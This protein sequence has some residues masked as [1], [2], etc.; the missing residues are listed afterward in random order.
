MTL[1]LRT[2]LVI[3][4][5]FGFVYGLITLFAPA[6][7]LQALGLAADPPAVLATRYFGAAVLGAG[8]MLYLARGA[9][10]PTM[11]R[12]L[13]VGNF[14]V[15][16]ASAAVSIGGLAAGLLNA[17]GWAFLASEVLLALGYGILALR[18]LRDPERPV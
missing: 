10:D 4:A 2:L 16:T 7:Y 11:Q 17:L 5:A 1:R 6:T 3:T 15:V 14:L 12:A 18:L 13:S 9:R 8:V